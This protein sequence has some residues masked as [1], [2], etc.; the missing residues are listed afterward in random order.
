MP[1]NADGAP[2]YNYRQ[3]GK[4][5]AEKILGLKYINRIA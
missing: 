4:K 2:F 5:I 1:I 3:K